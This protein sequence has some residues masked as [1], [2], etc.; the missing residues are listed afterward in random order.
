MGGATLAAMILAGKDTA[1][2]EL[3]LAIA[4]LGI[5]LTAPIG[6]L[7]ISRGSESLLTER[8]DSV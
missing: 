6:A 5:I 3:I 7:L 1:V 8:Q 4:V 2:G